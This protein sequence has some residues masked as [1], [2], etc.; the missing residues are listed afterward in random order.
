MDIFRLFEW[1]GVRLVAVVIVIALAILS[2]LLFVGDNMYR[3]HM[4]VLVTV[5]VLLALG[6]NLIFGYGGMIN[7]GF[8]AWYAFG[9]YSPTILANELGM[10]WL[11]SVIA[12]LTVFYFVTWLLGFVLLRLRGHYMALG[13]LSFGLLVQICI[14][15]F[16]RIT[17]G[18]DGLPTIRAAV[19][20][21]V[22][23]S[24]WY[25]ILLVI[26]VALTY[27]LCHVL[28]SSKVGRAFK[29][30]RDD[31]TAASTTGIDVGR[32]K[33]LCFC[34]GGTIGVFAGVLFSGAPSGYVVH[35]HMFGLGVMIDMLV[36]V[37]IGGLGS[38]AGAMLGGVIVAMLNIELSALA[39]Y[40]IIIF[41]FVFLIS[42]IF[43]P[44]GLAG[45]CK[46]LWVRFGRKKGVLYLGFRKESIS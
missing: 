14:D 3:V 39:A 7:F 30:I 38:N 45:L 19:G 37:V 18:D 33:R 15:L 28:V 6:L 46:S 43:F 9:A 23:T 12:T 21:Y 11:P 25:I 44:G 29:A 1:R 20:E 4:V 17:R 16:P 41:A 42:L 32:Y 27:Y 36:M 10:G 2:C 35:P 34:V 5:A 31:E 13:T 40:R 24:T 26:V 8:F 22:L